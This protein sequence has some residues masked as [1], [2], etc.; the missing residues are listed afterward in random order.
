MVKAA[1][2]LKRLKNLK[3]YVGKGLSWVNKNI[4][5]PLNPIIDTALD[6]VPGG[7]TIK[8]VKNMASN[9]LD[10]KYQDTRSNPQLQQFVRRGADMLLDTQRGPNDRRYI[11]YDDSD[12]EERPQPRKEYRNPFGKRIN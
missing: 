7:G 3:D 6:F 11:A 5:K 12:E 2:F 9:Y 8:T 1:G 10:Q 4:V